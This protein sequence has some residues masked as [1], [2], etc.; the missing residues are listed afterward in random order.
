MKTLEISKFKQKRDDF[1]NLCVKCSVLPSGS[2]GI[3]SNVPDMLQVKYNGVNYYPIG[4]AIKF[5]D[6]GS[7]MH[8]GILHDLKA[9]TTIDVE[10][11]KVVFM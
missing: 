6:D 9:N 3:K 10:L 4:Y 1:I 7:M 11:D 2:L 5:R 8:V